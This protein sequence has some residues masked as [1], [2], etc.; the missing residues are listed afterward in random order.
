MRAS[1]NLVRNLQQ[2]IILMNKI[3]FS[4]KTSALWTKNSEFDFSKKEAILAFQIPA[5]EIHKKGVAA[6]IYRCGHLFIDA[7]IYK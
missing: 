5:L 7:G 6:S 4:S 3:Q 1:I 2:I